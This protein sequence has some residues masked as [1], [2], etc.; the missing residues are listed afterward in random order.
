MPLLLLGQCQDPDVLICPWGEKTLD[1]AEYETKKVLLCW[2]FFSSN[3]LG[4]KN[5]I[6]RVCETTKV[7][8][9]NKNITGA[10]SVYFALLMSKTSLWIHLWATKHSGSIQENVENLMQE[11]MKIK[12]SVRFCYTVS[13]VIFWHYLITCYNENTDTL[14]ISVW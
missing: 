1:N 10:P 12:A 11:I 2:C 4:E 9:K 13:N 6:K 8:K 7:I 3:N 5:C 14:L